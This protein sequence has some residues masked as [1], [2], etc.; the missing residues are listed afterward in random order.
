[1][2]ACIASLLNA[3]IKQ[4]PDPSRLFNDDEPWM[5]RYN[6][7][8]AEKI[9]YR[10][11]P[12]PKSMCPRPDGQIWIAHISEDG[13]DDHALVA[14]GALVLHDPAGNYRGRLPLEQVLGGFLLVPTGRPIPVLRGRSAAFR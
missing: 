1:L 13:P 3:D 7:Q 4:V 9:G 11:D 10:L 14:R 12:L 2:K 6:R 5:E 8:L